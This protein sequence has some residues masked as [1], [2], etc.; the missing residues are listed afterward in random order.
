MTVGRL[1]QVNRILVQVYKNT[2]VLVPSVAASLA[3]VACTHNHDR[4]ILS[5]IWQTQSAPDSVLGLLK[6]GHLNG[7]KYFLA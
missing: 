4:G 1:R 6:P 3:S 2:R 7:L 5:G